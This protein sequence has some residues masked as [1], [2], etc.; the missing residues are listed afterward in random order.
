MREIVQFLVCFSS[1]TAVGIVLFMY[2]T[3]TLLSSVV[4]DVRLMACMSRLSV[5]RL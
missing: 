5:C 4:S 1:T 2:S 3:L